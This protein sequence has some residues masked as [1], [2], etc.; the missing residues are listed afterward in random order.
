MRTAVLALLLVLGLFV[1]PATAQGQNTLGLTTIGSTVDV[2]DSNF[3]T[4]SRVVTGA[5]PV[6]VT[7]VSVY[8]GPVDSAPRNQFSVAIYADSGGSPAALVAQSSNGTLSASA[9]NTLSVT[10][11][12]NA[13]SAYWLMYNTNGGN[14]SVNDLAFDNAS[15]NV[16]AWASRTFGSWPMTFGASSLAQQRYSIYATIQGGT[17]G[18][19]STPTITPTVTLTPTLGAATATPTA[20][21][22]VTPTPPGSVR[23]MPLGDSITYGAPEALSYRYYLGVMLKAAGYNTT[24]VGTL[25]SAACTCQDGL[26]PAPDP[27]TWNAR[28]EGHSGYTASMIAAG[29]AS[30]ASDAS[31]HPDIVLLHIGTNQPSSSADVANII[32]ALRSVNPSV[33]ILLAKIIPEA[34]HDW[35]AYNAS[36]VALA[37]QMTTAQ[38]PITIVDQ[39]Q[40]IVPSDLQADGVH[41]TGSGDL[42][43]AARWFVALQGVLP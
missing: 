6:S 42:K 8:V 35:A 9:W 30:W 33:K 12:L 1:A 20:T 11:S 29:I 24:F 15:L 28:N 14:Q 18:P 38:S 39:S 4:G 7:S 21:P 31:S 17:P 37:A 16:G 26:Q 32:N 41:P 13:S 34:L 40:W 27:T 43:I 2:F 25:I 36:L 19:T 10:A 23:I 3:M 22:T 5:A